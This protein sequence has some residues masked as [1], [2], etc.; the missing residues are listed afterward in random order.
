MTKKVDTWMP[1]L[2]DKYLGDTTH[3][4]TEQ[5]GAYLLLLMAMWKRDG[6][7]PASD[8]QLS[9]IARM[10]PAKWKAAKPVLMEFF[11]PTEDGAGITQKR[12]SEELERAN[13]MSARKAAAGA[14]G[15]QKRWQAGGKTNGSANA[16]ANGKS[17]G[18]AIADASQT[19]WQTGAPIPTPS[20]TQ[21]P[22]PASAGFSRA[23]GEGVG[24]GE[25][26]PEAG[27]QQPTAAG[28]ACRAIKAAGIIDVNPGHP[29]L[30]RL[31]AGGVTAQVLADTA[32]E[33]AGKGKAKFALLLA[34]VE[35][36][37]R[38][39]AAAGSLPA[40]APAADPWD[41][42]NG[43]EAFARELGLKAWDET[44]QFAEYRRTVRAAY[45]RRHAA[46]GA[47]T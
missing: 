1:L 27:G 47:T 44:C 6:V 5:H 3:L 16:S 39:A 18:N 11:T 25:G 33:L 14:V 17:D 45:D 2:V 36:R 21:I 29:H 34:T 24:T 28:L 20:A 35:G 42:R 22:N 8:A 7:L 10:Q 15:A 37:L 38:D 9:A 26:P 12:L 19:Q 41:T 31:L 23:P 40:G 32:T 13:A 43:V 30:L 4:T 46:A